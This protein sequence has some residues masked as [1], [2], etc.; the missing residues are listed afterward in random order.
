MDLDAPINLEVGGINHENER[1]Q[2]CGRECGPYYRSPGTRRALAGGGGPR[3]ELRRRLCLRCTI[4]RYLLQAV[5]P[6]ATPMSRAGALLPARG[7][8][9]AGRLSTLPSMQT[10]GRWAHSPASR[11]DPKRVPSD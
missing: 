1:N 5:V 4:D 8:R 11:V 7:S 2:L 6:F 9:R 10:A 3:S